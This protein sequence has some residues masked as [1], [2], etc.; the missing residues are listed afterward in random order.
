VDLPS[1]YTPEGSF[2]Y[3]L[4]VLVAALAAAV[5]YLLAFTNASLPL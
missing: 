2:A 5:A 4:A 1:I 3:L